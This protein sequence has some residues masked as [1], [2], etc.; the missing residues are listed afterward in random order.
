MSKTALVFGGT[1]LVGRQLLDLLVEDDAWDKVVCVARRP[2]YHPSP[3]VIELI[4]DADTLNDTT[5]D[6]A[7]DVVFCCLGTTQKTAGSR[8]GFRKIDYDYVLA[9]AKFGKDLGAKK[10]LLVSSVGAEVGSFSFYAHVKGEAERDVSV[11]GYEC[12]EILRPS[13]LLGDRPERRLKE[14]IGGAILPW[15]S[16][17]FVG[18]LKQYHPIHGKQVAVAMA[19]IAKLDRTG[20][21]IHSSDALL[22]YRQNA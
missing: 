8:E 17:L 22:R 4:A 18:P 14:D 2:I 19:E 21:R 12:L 20:T 13:L 7:I 11:L 15:L 1:G 9:A 10:L 16:F 6:I 3:K 5:C